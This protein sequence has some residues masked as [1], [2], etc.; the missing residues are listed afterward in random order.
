MCIRDR[1]ISFFKRDKDNAPWGSLQ[2]PIEK[3]IELSAGPTSF[4]VW[5]KNLSTTKYDVIKRKVFSARDWV[6]KGLN[7][8]DFG[9][10]KYDK[11]QFRD[12]T[13]DVFAHVAKKFSFYGK[14]PE[15]KVI[16]VTFTSTDSA[17][18]ENKF[19]VVEITQGEGFLVEYKGLH[20]ANTPASMKPRTSDDAKYAGSVDNFI[21]LKDGLGDDCNGQLVINNWQD[22]KF[23]ADGRS[24]IPHGENYKK[25]GFVDVI[26]NYVGSDGSQG[27]KH[28]RSLT[29]GDKKWNI[30][31]EG[32][33]GPATKTVRLTGSG[34]GTVTKEIMVLSKAETKTVELKSGVD[35]GCY[36]TS[37]GLSLIHI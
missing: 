19:H 10:D 4:Q 28:M 27:G 34:D 11:H 29:I 25:N 13:F 12:I 37:S 21:C 3:S 6:G 35:Y 33:S 17:D 22:A 32:N 1:E 7:E 14:E 31:N 8:D 24:I 2:E 36:F 23:G 16:D 9:G 18:Y 15:R 30:N 26:V 5:V 20:S